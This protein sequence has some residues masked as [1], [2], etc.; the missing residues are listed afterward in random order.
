M[1][2]S[3][4]TN[5][6]GHVVRRCPVVP[7]QS[8]LLVNLRVVVKSVDPTGSLGGAWGLLIVAVILAGREVGHGIGMEVSERGNTNPLRH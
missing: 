3:F 8:I 6:L 7:R 4:L 1:R 2:G 5:L